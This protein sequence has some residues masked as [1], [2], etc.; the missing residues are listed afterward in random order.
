MLELVQMATQILSDCCFVGLLSRMSSKLLHQKLFTFRTCLWAASAF[1]AVLVT[2]SNPRKM[3]ALLLLFQVAT[4]LSV[5][6]SLPPGPASDAA[7][8]L[9]AVQ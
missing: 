7:M 3:L 6:C 8:E 9:R 1:V 4:M 2:E 5:Y